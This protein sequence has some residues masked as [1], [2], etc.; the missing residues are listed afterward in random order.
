VALEHATVTN[1]V[2]GLVVPVQFN[3]EEYAISKEVTY[4]QSAIP[5]V[6]GPLLQFV[7]G[8]MSTLEMDLLLDT[9]ES[10]R[11]GGRV[12]NQAGDDVRVLVKRITD[13]MA[14][15]SSTHAPPVLLFTW[16]SLTFTCVLARA[17]QKFQM[18]SST[19]VPVRAR[20]QVTFNEFRNIELEAKEIK[21]QT[22][23]YTKRRVVGQGETLSA[24]AAD[25]YGDPSLWRPLAVVNEIDDPRTPAAGLELV[26]PRLPF[27]DPQTA[28]VTA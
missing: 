16:G 17:N 22:A 25:V 1:T 18:F 6:S 19:G 27:T 20:V 14:I 26:V 12:V 3:P 4:A 28:A 23:D 2:T 9:L 21:R 15:D 11:S 13:L 10:H 24:I 8:N 7:H 5:G